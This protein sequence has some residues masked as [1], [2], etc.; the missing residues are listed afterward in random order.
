MHQAQASSHAI[1]G[2]DSNIPYLTT[3]SLASQPRPHCVS[4]I[5][6]QSYPFVPSIAA[7]SAIAAPGCE[8]SDPWVGCLSR[9]KG[10]EASVYACGV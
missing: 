3:S 10:I 5:T 9:C 6:P 1:S 8:A 7:S 2:F 4:P